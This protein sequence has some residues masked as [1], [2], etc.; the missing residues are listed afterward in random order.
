MIDGR[1]RKIIGLNMGHDAG[2]ALCVDGKVIAHMGEERLVRV[3]YAYGWL[4]SLKYCLETSG[5]ELNDID[6]VVFSDYGDEIGEKYGRGLSL[7]S[8]P[9]KRCIRADHHLSHACSTFF[10][11]PFEKSLVFVFDARGNNQDTESIYTAEGNRIKKIGGNPLRN[12]EKGIVAA[13]QAFTAYF[14]WHQNEAGK[15]MGLAP[16]GDS[17]KYSKWPIFSYNKDDLFSNSLPDHTADGLER[18]CQKRRLA[19][20]PKFGNDPMIYKDMAAW[21]Q[22][23]FE[24]VVIET[25]KKYQQLTGLENLCMAGGG[26]LNTVCNTRILRETGIKKLHIF[27]AA[28]DPGQSIGNALYGYYIY[29]NHPR[30]KF[31]IWKKDYRKNTYMSKDIQKTLSTI[32]RIANLIVPKSPNFIFKKLDNIVKVTAKLIA[33]GKIVGWF[34]GGSEIGPRALGHRSIL[35]DPRPENMKDIL[36]KKVKHRE[37]FRPFAASVLRSNVKDFFKLDIGSSFMLLVVPVKE[38]IRSKISAVTHID[39]TC[40][41]QT[42]TKQDN[43]IYY[44]LINEFYRLTRIPLILNTSFN[45]AGEP[46]VETPTD[47]L[48]CFLS[49]Q[50]D[51]LVIDKFLVT[52][53]K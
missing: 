1:V 38:E 24:K 35:C 29:G 53:L 41:I 52:K 27:P 45:L 32:Q 5:Y 2:C 18:F 20:P 4:N 49:T 47:A 37:S 17:Q 13:Y 51:Y 22:S 14:G 23:E 44:D 7:F 46:I 10:T 40:R 30:N 34:Q 42:V 28:G 8:F 31:Y 12:Y 33:D 6:L 3:K 50:M 19:I 39:G 25:I 36:N 15:T 21:I 16:F 26:A 43:G 48:K 9:Q 11:S